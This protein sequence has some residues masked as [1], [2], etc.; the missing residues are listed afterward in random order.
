MKLSKLILRAGILL[1]FS[2]NIL[3]FEAAPKNP[4]LANSTYAIGHGNSAQQDAVSVAGPTGPSRFLNENEKQYT[5]MG[6]MHFGSL[7]T[8]EYENGKRVIWS[9]GADRI[10]KVDHD[11]NKVID[12]VYFSGEEEYTKKK[13]DRVIKNLNKRDGTDAIA[14]ALLQSRMFKNLAGVYTLLDKDNN[15]YLGTNEGIVVYGDSINGKPSSKIKKLR[16]FV[17]PKE[18]TGPFIGMNMTFDGRVV[19]VTEHGFVMVLERDFSN[20]SYMKLKFSE[21]ADDNSSAGKGWVRNGFSIDKNGGI[22]IAS[23]KHMHKIIWNGKKLSVDEKDGAWTAEYSNIKGEGTGSTPALMGFEDE[24]QFVVMTDGDDLMNL[25]LFW[26]NEIPKDWKKI[27]GVSEKRVAA[28]VAVNMGDKNRKSLQSEQ[29]VVIAGYGAAVVNNEPRNAPSWLPKQAGAL[30]VGFLGNQIEFQPFGVQKFEWDPKTRRF[31][32]AWVNKM[33]S[34][35]NSMPIVSLGSNM[36]YTV[37]ARNGKWTVE[38]INWSTGKS[39]A[40]Y[41]VGDQRFNSLYSGILLDENGDIFYGTIF[42]KVRIKLD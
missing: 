13:A 22:Y 12:V 27:E 25:T 7:I 2:T 41:V 8:S 17:R 30:L 39:H 10:V 36:F 42:G 29:S 34:S 26:R 18:V 37:G 20:F 33:I 35:P 1:S 14:Y 16:E 3:A 40:H 11:S 31:E 5:H 38:A 4:F 28:K 24:D 19:L 6:P 23:R 15:Y 32:Q 21:N 9:N